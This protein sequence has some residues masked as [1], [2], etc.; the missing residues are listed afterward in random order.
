MR[1]GKEVGVNVH[2]ERRPHLPVDD[3]GQFGEGRY[4]AGEDGG[5]EASAGGVEREGGAWGELFGGS[6]AREDVEARVTR[7]EAEEGILRRL[8]T[9]EGMRGKAAP[10]D[11]LARKR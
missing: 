7:V 3:A 4:G 5:A 10:R 1:A 6:E 2:D 9:S 11:R 8:R